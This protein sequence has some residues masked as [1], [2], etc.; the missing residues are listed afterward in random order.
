MKREDDEKRNNETENEN[1]EYYFVLPVLFD[2]NFEL[3]LALFFAVAGREIRD[4]RF[5]CRL[6][7]DSFETG[8]LDGMS[9]TFLEPKEPCSVGAL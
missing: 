8:F 9:L 2:E 7:C 6:A 1:E 4:S 5:V 3:A